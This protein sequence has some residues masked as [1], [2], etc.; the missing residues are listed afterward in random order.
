MEFS[1]RKI[2]FINIIENIVKNNKDVIEIACKQRSKFEGWLKFELIR[3]LIEN[4]DIIIE[5]TVENYKIDLAITDNKGEELYVELKTCNTSYKI[6]GVIDKSKPITK[7]INNIIKDVNKL[8]QLN[9]KGKVVF[10]VFPLPP[11]KINEFI[12]QHLKKIEKDTGIKINHKFHELN[13]SY[14]ILICESDFI[15]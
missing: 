3:I 15:N 1:I 2:D 13:K 6:D 14:G 10:I 4:F 7:N 11:D 9:N 8:K 5:K 12:E